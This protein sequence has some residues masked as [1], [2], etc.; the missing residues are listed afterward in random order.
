MVD[1]NRVQVTRM[2]GG[3][4]PDR[5]AGELES[6]V[7]RPDGALRVTMRTIGEGM[8]TVIDFDA[9]DV[10]W[11]VATA[12]PEPQKVIAPI[13]SLSVATAVGDIMVRLA[14]LTD[15]VDGHHRTFDEAFD[16]IDD[17]EA[18]VRNTKAPDDKWKEQVTSLTDSL[19][20]ADKELRRRVIVLES[21]VRGLEDPGDTSS[22][23]HALI[24]SQRRRLAE[25]GPW[26]PAFEGAAESA[27]ARIPDDAVSSVDD[28]PKP[29][30]FVGALEL[31]RKALQDIADGAR[32]PVSVAWK[33]LHDA[34]WAAFSEKANEPLRANVVTVAS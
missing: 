28:A 23:P 1:T 20:E 6:V 15:K 27:A 18:E 5:W 30:E 16:R 26:E 31:Y 13:E 4:I 7:R 17:L 22:L 2:G 29:V 3:D 14:A 8:V 9:D 25:P 21:R 12:Q 19:V 11:I 34:S 33:V 24:E 32:D 10:G